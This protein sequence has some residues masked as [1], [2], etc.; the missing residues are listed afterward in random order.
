MKQAFLILSIA[1]LWTASNAQRIV[2]VSYSVDNQG[3]YIFICNNKDYCT[4]VIHVDFT[5]LVNAKAD[6]ALPY[7]AEVKPGINKLLIVS[8]LN[9]TDDTKVNF[10]SS[11]RK[12]CLSP[13]VN[14]GFVYLL[15][16]AP[17]L[18]TQAYIIPNAKGAGS[19]PGGQDSGY[20]VR[21]RAKMGDTIYAARR[22]IVTAVDVSNTENDAGAS[23]T[24]N[25]NYVEIAQAD[26]SFAQYGVLKK[27][28]AFVKPGQTVE[29][30]TPIGLVG[31]DRYGR[32]SDVRFSVSY[33]P[34]VNNTQIPLL[35]WTKGNSNGG[36]LRQGATYLSEFPKALLTQ[37]LPKKPKPAPH[38]KH[39]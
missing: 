10:K 25:W 15:P 5:T 1:F 3:R 31:G 7:E 30:G 12:G 17:G 20:A 23:T 21:L 24:S 2:D 8:P 4:Y 38:Q 16:I 9:K 27:D 37:E 11:Y 33:Y 39:I 13:I 14:A 26:C 18:E 22:G 32:G 6:H 36:P 29:A 35:F 19:V 34:G 28:G